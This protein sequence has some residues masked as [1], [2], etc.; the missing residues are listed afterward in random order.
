MANVCVITGGGKGIGLEAAKCQSKEKILVLAGNKIE[1]LENAVQEMRAR[2]YTVFAKHCDVSNL[3][4][5]KELAEFACKLGNVKTLIHT[6]EL[7][8]K[9]PTAEQILMVNV[10]GTVYV[11]QI[12]AKV[13]KTGG[14]IVDI[15]S[16]TAHEIPVYDVPKRLYPLS[17]TDAPTFMQKLLKRIMSHKEERKQKEFAYALSK[18]FT[19]WYAKKCAM[20]FGEKGIRAVSVSLGLMDAEAEG[21][22]LTAEKRVGKA[23]EIGYLLATVADERNGYLTGVDIL[24]DGGMTARKTEFKN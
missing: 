23:A 2:G 21:V 11:N 8:A 1:T 16:Y 7:S 9:A 13:M 12:F 15:G 14:V 17:E 3:Q 24:C 5:V 6:A 19:I 10:F 20:E 4:S 18:N 22:A